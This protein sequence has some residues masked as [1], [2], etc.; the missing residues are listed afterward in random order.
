MKRK[1]NLYGNLYNLANIE[2][3]FSEIEKK[4]LI[5]KNIN[6]YTYHEFMNYL[7]KGNIKLD[8]IMFFIYMN[9]KKG[10]L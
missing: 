6:V 8:H 9:L 7:S 5:L 1:N 10:E 2:E 4:L 3:A